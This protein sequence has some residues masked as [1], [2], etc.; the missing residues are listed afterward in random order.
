ML[1]FSPSLVIADLDGTMLHDAYTFEGRYLSSE[2]VQAAERLRE[3]GIPLAII[4]ARPVGS[5]FDF[6]HDLKAQVCAYLNGALIDFDCAHS[7]VSELT[8][9]R[10]IDTLTRFGFDSQHASDVCLRLLDKIPT[11]RLGIVMN[12][13]RYTNFDV[14]MLWNEQ[15]FVIT[16]FSD[17][18][19][20]IADKIIIV[21]QD[22]EKNDLQR[23]IPDDFSL[24]ISEDVLWMLTNPLAN[25]GHALNV[26]C[27]RLG[28][29]PSRTVVF[30]DD[31][32]DIDM[33]RA[34]G[35]GVAVANSNQRL[36]AIADE[37]CASNN[38]DGVATWLKTNFS[39]DL[40]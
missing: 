26:I 36:L 40:L 34:G 2:T 20:G 18:P 19:H 10:N 4:T 24:H 6:V 30:G 38:D 35:Y 14:R 8:S 22:S 23:I 29:K 3:S 7:T 31:I 17:V 15:D 12:D 28:V 39:S 5:A 16:D 11:L 27:D 21:P 13:V 32:I 33:F 1:R 9:Q 25:K 37:V